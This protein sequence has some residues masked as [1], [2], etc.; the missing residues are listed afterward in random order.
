MAEDADD[1]ALDDDS[2][3]Y[4]P[5]LG[6]LLV[7]IVLYAGALV[8]ASRSTTIAIGLV[9]VGGVA[10]LAGTLVSRRRWRRKSRAWIAVANTVGFLCIVVDIASDGDASLQIPGSLLIVGGTLILIWID[11]APESGSTR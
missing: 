3:T 6:L 9:V 4:W 8:V 11:K 10:F 5:A 7:S 2:V 1:P